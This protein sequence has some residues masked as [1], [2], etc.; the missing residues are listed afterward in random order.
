MNIEDKSSENLD[1]IKD[2]DKSNKIEEI[3]VFSDDEYI[4]E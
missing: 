3:E 2:N 4:I 1:I